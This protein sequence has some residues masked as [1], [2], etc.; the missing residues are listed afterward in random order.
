MT[1]LRRSSALEH[2]PSLRAEIGSAV[3]DSGRSAVL[4]LRHPIGL[5][6]VS[7]FANDIDAAGDRLSR[8]T[9]LPLPSPL[10][11]TGTASSSLR[12]IG[13]GVWHVAGE[14]DEIPDADALRVMLEPVA[15]VV[16]L[17]HART[18]L[19]LG[20][21]FAARVIAKHCGVDL[22]VAMFPTG[23]V[24]GTRF[25][26]LGMTLA[27]LDDAPTFELMVFRGYA[28]FVYES[29]IEAARE[30]SDDAGVNPRVDEP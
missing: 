10:R 12:A 1:M 30:F 11:M 22:D 9:G 24:T 13:P 27:R 14:P 2:H 23:T 16:D 3:R 17:S 15:T 26:Q 21:P 29:L 8:E 19:H 25:N 7:A 5:L 18:V 4:S 28:V 20:G 6:Q